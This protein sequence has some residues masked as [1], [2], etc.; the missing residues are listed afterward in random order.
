[1]QV[2]ER[3]LNDE[4]VYYVEHQATILGN[5]DSGVEPRPFIMIE[6]TTK[7]QAIALAKLLSVTN[8]IYLEVR[9]EQP[10]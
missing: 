10:G 5:E 3:K 6:C 2:V 1:M 4:I 8:D 7:A 9:D